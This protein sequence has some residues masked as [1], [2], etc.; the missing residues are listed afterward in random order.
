VVELVTGAELVEP[1]VLVTGAEL[2]EPEVLVT[3]AGLAEP[4]VLVTAVPQAAQTV[5]EAGTFRGA[6]AET[7]ML[8]VEA[9]V[10]T[11]DRAPAP[12]AAVALPAWEAAA[13]EVVGVPAADGAGKR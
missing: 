6:A 7:G 11:T 4:E 13:A 10:V 9:I 3:E 2:A 12:T 5:S 8:S 1:E